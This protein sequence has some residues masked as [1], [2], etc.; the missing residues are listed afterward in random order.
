MAEKKP[1]AAGG[2][3]ADAKGGMSLAQNAIAFAVAG[4]IAGGVGAFHGMQVKPAAAAS[5]DAPAKDG[6]KPR[7]TRNSSR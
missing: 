1:K 4:L 7:T 3:D 6:G 5:K 2:K